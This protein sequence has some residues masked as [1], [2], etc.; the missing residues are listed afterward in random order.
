MG[1]YTCWTLV[2]ALECDLEAARPSCDNN[3]VD[4]RNRVH[5]NPNSWKTDFLRISEVG[6]LWIPTMVWQTSSG[7][8]SNSIRQ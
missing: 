6:P 1:I 4:V 5:E 2:R 7:H 8:S 3:I